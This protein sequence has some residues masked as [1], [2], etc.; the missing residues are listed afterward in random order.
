MDVFTACRRLQ[1][2]AAGAQ[3]GDE[4]SSHHDY[5]HIHYIEI[6]TSIDSDI[7]GKR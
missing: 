5:Q 6:N 7:E 1:T 2:T 4:F 3:P